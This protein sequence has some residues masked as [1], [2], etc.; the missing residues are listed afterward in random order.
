MR[1][2]VRAALRQQRASGCTLT[3]VIVSL[4]PGRSCAQEGPAFE[5]SI[6]L[7][8]CCQWLSLAPERLVGLEWPANWAL[9]QPAAG[10]RV[11]APLGGGGALA[12]T[13]ASGARALLCPCQ[14]V[15]SAA[16]EGS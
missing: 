1:E 6:A 7:G 3:R 12:G 4:R 10:S 5:T 8:C 16:G 15:R 9:T 2:R 14:M 11:I 13:A